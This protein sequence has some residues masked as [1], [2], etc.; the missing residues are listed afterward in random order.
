LE[1][2]ISPGTTA[3]QSW[4]KRVDGCENVI[5]ANG[6][7]VE[8]VAVCVAADEVFAKV[9]INGR[10]FSCPGISVMMTLIIDGYEFSHQGVLCKWQCKNLDSCASAGRPIDFVSVAGLVMVQ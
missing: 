5:A 1:Q 3:N 8:L 7:V 10:K 9:P 2:S 6:P 4:G